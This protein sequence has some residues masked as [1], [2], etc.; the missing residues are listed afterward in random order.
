MV[1]STAP[2]PALLTCNVLM[3]RWVEAPG[4]A[5]TVVVVAVVIAVFVLPGVTVPDALSIHDAWQLIVPEAPVMIC[6]RSAVEERI[7]MAANLTDSPLSIAMR[8]PGRVR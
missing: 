5:T 1:I 3:L 6:S 2:A 4:E 7:S 8:R